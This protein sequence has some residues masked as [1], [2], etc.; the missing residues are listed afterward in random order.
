MVRR[1]K[2]KFVDFWSD[3]NFEDNFIINILREKYICELSN[4]PDYLFSKS[5]LKAVKNVENTDR[6][7]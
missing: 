1:I 2:I 3:F 7:L 4:N 5:V 6:F